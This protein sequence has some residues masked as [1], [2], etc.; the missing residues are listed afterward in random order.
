M[1]LAHRLPSS[2]ID[3][4]FP[5][6]ASSREKFKR[7]LQL[8]DYMQKHMTFSFDMLLHMSSSYP[9]ISI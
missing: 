9:D 8:R 4:T 2:I 6:V 5:K 3:A 1:A 7:H